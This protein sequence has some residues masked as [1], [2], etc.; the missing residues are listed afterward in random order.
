MNEGRVMY[1][2]YEAW[3]ANLRPQH[4]HNQYQGQRPDFVGTVLATK[5]DLS[6]TPGTYMVLANLNFQK[7]TFN[8]PTLTIPHAYHRTL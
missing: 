3:G 4:Y 8:L 7:L 1:L 6:S 2:M 5:P